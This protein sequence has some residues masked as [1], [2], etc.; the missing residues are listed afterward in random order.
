MAMNPAV[1]ATEDL[2]TSAR[3]YGVPSPI[4]SRGKQGTERLSSSMKACRV[5]AA[6]GSV[7]FKQSSSSAAAPTK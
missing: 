7:G 1:I 2:Q 3:H 4:G 6:A 5:L